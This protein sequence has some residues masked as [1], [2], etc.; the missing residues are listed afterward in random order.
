MAAVDSDDRD[1]YLCSYLRGL[2]ATL[3]CS[4]LTDAADLIEELR[5]ALYVEREKVD[6][7][8]APKPPPEKCLPGR[9]GLC[10]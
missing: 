8:E 3:A 4:E 6:M 10:R 9:R 1:D 5:A 2:G 7:Y